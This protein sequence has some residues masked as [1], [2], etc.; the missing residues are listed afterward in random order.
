MA[1]LASLCP[2]KTHRSP[3]RALDPG[4]D[5]A[6]TLQLVRTDHF[7]VG[8]D[9]QAQI[10]RDY[11]RVR[12][13]AGHS[14]H[15]PPKGR[16]YVPLTAVLNQEPTRGVR[17]EIFGSDHLNAA[18]CVGEISDREYHFGGVI[19]EY[20]VSRVSF[21]NTGPVLGPIRVCPKQEATSAT[22]SRSS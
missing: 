13:M 10:D 6:V 8:E 14:D 21:R 11:W 2:P 16:A 18:C 12:V 1:G 9:D 22:S 15:M 3:A 20:R 7:A 4:K 19:H 17:S 5:V